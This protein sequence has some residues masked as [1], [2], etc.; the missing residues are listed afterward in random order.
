[1]CGQWG[2]NPRKLSGGLSTGPHVILPAGEAWGASTGPQGLRSGLRPRVLSPGTWLATRPGAARTLGAP[3]APGFPAP[4]AP[5]AARTPKGLCSGLAVD[6]TGKLETFPG[7]QLTGHQPHSSECAKNKETEG[8]FQM[9][10]LVFSFVFLE[11][12]FSPRLQDVWLGIW[13][14]AV[15]KWLF[16]LDQ[17]LGT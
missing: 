3:A 6:F 9:G 15:T 4:A 14:L 5:S 17:P 12:M 16:N 1:M 10:L 11:Q 13:S 8:H 7:S 2:L